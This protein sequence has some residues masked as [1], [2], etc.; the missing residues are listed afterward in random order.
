[1][2]YGLY[3]HIPFC[4]KKCIYCDFLSF[5]SFDIHE[6]DK[7]KY[8]HALEEDWYTKLNIF[9]PWDHIDSI[10][11]GGG[12]PSLVDPFYIDTLLRVIKSDIYVTKNAEITIEVNPGTVD[13]DKLE[14]YVSSGINRISIGVQ[15]TQDR[16]LRSLGRIH[17]ASDCEETFKMA[18]EAG[19]RN[20]SCDLILGIPQIKNEPGQ[21]FEELCEDVENVL[22]WGAR[23]ISVYSIIIEEGTPLCELF[24]RKKAF[25]IDDDLERKMYR[26]VSSLA[27]EYY[28]SQYEISNYARSDTKSAHNMK[29]WKCLPYIG[30]GLGAA[31]YYPA[32]KKK[33]QGDY[34]R[35]SNTRIITDYNEFYFKGESEIISV[36][37]QM[38]EYMMLGFRKISGPD[39]RVFKKRF[40]CYYHDKFKDKLEMLASK[41]LITFNENA[42]LTKKGLDFANEVFR[43]FV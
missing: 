5:N 33:P 11:I 32:D 21:T 3:I 22:K 28:L 7:F 36:E 43:E 10:Y 34:I 16:L 1:M 2:N 29:Y 42:R 35:S 38:N 24:E 4:V 12:T 6:K 37:E 19:F 30:L 18:K 8:F 20:I 27:K 15:S 26:A 39:G 41:G 9:N 25:E 23:H 13:I 14:K 40:G 17:N 31:S